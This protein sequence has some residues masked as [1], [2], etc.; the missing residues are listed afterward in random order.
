MLILVVLTTLLGDDVANAS[1]MQFG[2]AKVEITPDR[3]LRLS[4]YSNR[5]RPYDA[6]ESPLFAR[7]LAIRDDR[8]AL[9]VWTV[10]ETLGVTD[11][12]R[13]AVVEKAADLGLTSERFTYCA[14][15]THAAP[16]LRGVAPNLFSPR[17]DAAE[18]DAMNLYTDDVIDKT[19]E[20]IR[21][22][23]A[24]LAPGRLMLG[25][26]TADFAANRR[27]LKDGKWA[28]FGVQ[29]D[30]PTDHRVPVLSVVDPAGKIRAVIYLYACHATTLGGEFNKISGDWPGYASTLVEEKYPGCVALGMIGCGADANPNPR[31][32]LE[33]AKRHGLAI[34]DAVTRSLGG[35]QVEVTSP[36]KS[37]YG[38][39]GL[40]PVRPSAAELTLKLASPNGHVRQHAQ[41]MLAVL[42]DFGRIPETYPAPIQIHRFG[43][44]LLMIFLGGEVVVDYALR[45]QR[46]LADPFAGHRL[47]VAAY[48]NDVFA[49]VPSERMIEEGGYEYDQSMLFYD[50]PGPW[51]SGTED[52]L[53]GRVHDLLK[54]PGGEGNLS[55]EDALRS[56]I[57]SDG[58]VV[59]LVASE[60]LIADPVNIAFGPD[61]RLWVAEMGDYPT[62]PDGQGAPDGRVRYLED[63]DGDG[64]FDKSTLFLKDLKYTT[65]VHPWRKGVIVASTPEIFYAED[66]FDEGEA[67][68]R[69]TIVSGFAVGNPQHVVTGFSM[70]LDNW[71]YFCGDE[72]GTVRSFMTGNAVSLAGRDGRVRP[73]T[74][75]LD[76]TSGV[77]QHVRCRDDWGNWFGGA[78]PCPFWHYVLDDA[79]TRRN[80]YVATPRPWQDLYGGFFPLVFPKSRIVDRF[81]D[82]FTA[83][84]FT[85]ACSPSPYRDKLLGPAEQIFA[86]EPVHNLVHR[87]HIERDGLE[88][89]AKRAPSEQSSEF[90]ASSDPWCRPVRVVTGPDGAVY[91]VDMYRLVI[92]HPQWIPDAWK[93]RLDLR[94][95][96][97]KGRIYRVYPKE[98]KPTTPMLPR[99]AD[100]ADDELVGH[101]QS[102]NGWHRDMAQ[103]LLITRHA[104]SVVPLIRT[105]AKDG[106]SPKSRL[107]ALGTL[108]GL[109]AL[110]PDDVL[111]ALGDDHPAVRV[112]ALRLSEP[113]LREDATIAA[114]VSALAQDPEITVRF[115]A[116]HSLGELDEPAAAEAVAQIALRDIDNAWIR[117]A[118]LAS[119]IHHPEV[120]LRRVLA[121]GEPT[122]D[123]SALI[124]GLLAT[125]VGL[126]GDEGLPRVLAE[127][128]PEPTGAIQDWQFD[129]AGALL[130]SLDRRELSLDRWAEKAVENAS[131]VDRL[132]RLMAEARRLAASDTDGV[133]ARVRAARL[134]GRGPDQPEGD[135]ELLEELLAPHQPIEVQ[136]AAVA[137]L[138]RLRT[139]KTPSLLL[140]AW[141]SFGPSVRAACVSVLLA[142][143]EWA[144]ALLAGIEQGNVQPSE[145]DTA[146]RQVLLDH[147]R[148]EIQER[149]RKVFE[150]GS[151]LSRKEIVAEYQSTTS[152]A[153]NNERGRE[154]FTKHCA[155]C[156]RFHGIGTE[157][158]A[159]L[160][161]LND[162]SPGNLL[163][164]VL[165]PNRAVEA[166][167]VNYSVRLADGRV[168]SG[169]I[170]RET[171]SNITLAK[172]DGTTEDILR[173]DIDE[174][175]SSGKSFMPEGFEKDLGPQ[176]LADIFEFLKV[177]ENASPSMPD[178]P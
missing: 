74:G 60:P 114:R 158:G 173:V 44:D 142:R 177:D 51:E 88:F 120:V 108:L 81:N 78:N 10:V 76:S 2:A 20:S 113:I 34:A 111:A 170:V 90:L 35:K 73:D 59:E 50:Q 75:E 54:Q 171:T 64:T 92:E 95:G 133:S 85:S 63:S 26:S 178:S 46:E 37:T 124:D 134:L 98:R 154:L 61:G 43:D 28:G 135:L 153:G 109:Q 66:A 112:F 104:T 80:R 79:Y 83:G 27:L 14:T 69:Q 38:F 156:H 67:S 21:R 137:E 145:I 122:R 176:D 91:V 45:L 123:H 140:R 163:V 129:A 126:F 49:Y 72:L 157:V 103:Q 168:L 39:A 148:Q 161:T 77:T 71:L 33:L 130:D 102:A 4:G 106:K 144:S 125:T 116:A 175:A 143:P 162:R 128:L 11:A 86:C 58:L 23:I 56:M 97:D 127:I 47:W 152:L 107:N 41:D 131:L 139:D 87:A 115:Q 29:S 12:M 164:A 13:K 40:A 42:E 169:M 159:N 141:R 151:N 167:F 32:S 82:L 19:I 22:A 118:V 24:N 57:P 65:G 165:D 150:T 70:G 36:P 93:A 52:L 101:L 136:T 117:A 30:G 3:P 5:D 94:A 55:P 62:G 99:L 146:S 48:S 160:A 110:T 147:D 53:I 105:T 155:A 100:C 119:S 89:R 84:R 138:G 132:A 31:G 172:P 121:H 68:V 18:T 25:E 6:V 166:K 9:T 174:M 8:D 149:A 1:T 16:H 7:S 96:H 17:L 15:H